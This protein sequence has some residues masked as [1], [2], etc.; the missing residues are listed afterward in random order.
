MTSVTSAPVPSYAIKLEVQASGR[1]DVKQAYACGRT[2]RFDSLNYRL[3]GPPEDPGRVSINNS[4]VELIC[5]PRSGC[6]KDSMDYQ[7]ERT[8]SVLAPVCICIV[9]ELR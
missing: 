9:P 1:R 4:E 5:N 6:M 2:V 3:R 7:E 8:H